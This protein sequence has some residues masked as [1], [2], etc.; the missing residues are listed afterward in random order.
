M[1]DLLH[2]RFADD[3]RTPQLFD[4]NAASRRSKPSLRKQAA[5]TDL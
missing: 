5:G 2:A 1:L 3:A 4:D